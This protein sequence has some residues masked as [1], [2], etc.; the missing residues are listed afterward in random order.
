VRDETLKLA[1][2][3]EGER[4]TALPYPVF[5]S[6]RGWRQISRSESVKGSKRSPPQMVGVRRVA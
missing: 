1:A 5:R 3:H 2:E 4:F 6:W